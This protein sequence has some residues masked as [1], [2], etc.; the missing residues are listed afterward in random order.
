MGSASVFE[1]IWYYLGYYYNCGL[2]IKKEIGCAVMCEY[3][4]AFGTL[5]R[6][7]KPTSLEGKESSQSPVKTK[8]IYL[9]QGL[10]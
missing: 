2:G 4:K 8:S 7:N 1:N 6:K 5:Q 3:E 10:P 9:K